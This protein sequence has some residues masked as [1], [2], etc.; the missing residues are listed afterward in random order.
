MCVLAPHMAFGITQRV[1]VDPHTGL[2]IFGY[3][4]VSF[5]IGPAPRQG[6]PEIELMWSG[7]I[8][9]FANDGN[10]AAFKSHPQR[11]APRF[12]GYDPVL[13]ARGMLG[14]GD[15]TMFVMD[16]DQL[17]FFANID[18]LRLWDVERVTAI[19][20]AERNWLRVRPDLVK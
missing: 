11:Y 17:L 9:R 18:N 19:A 20:Q 3:D 12:G 15:P 1:V 5:F 16:D 6:A 7:A 4:P 8:W 14:A 13:L 10:R 2:A